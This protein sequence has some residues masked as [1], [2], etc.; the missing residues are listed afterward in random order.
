MSFTPIT[1]HAQQALARLTSAFSQAPNAR[2]IIEV[3][4]QM[5]Q[6]IEDATLSVAQGQLAKSGPMQGAALD[7]L[8]R[9]VGQTRGGLN[10][11]TYM[12]VLLGTIGRNNSDATLAAVTHV[13]AQIFQ[14]QAVFAATPNAPVSNPIA[15]PAAVQLGLGTPAVARALYGRLLGIV[16]DTRGSGITLANIVTFDT[17]GA[18]APDGPQP[19]VKGFSELDGSGGG[20]LA[21][22]ISTSD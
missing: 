17:E 18:L 20:V 10:D 21:D 14:T 8:G 7:V 4:A 5:V 9:I 15:A 11:A 22:L 12:P 2:G 13:A 3:F 1:D 19:W 6:A 16:R